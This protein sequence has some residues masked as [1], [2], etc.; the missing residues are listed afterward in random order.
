MTNDLAISILQQLASATVLGSLF[1][2]G[3]AIAFRWIRNTSATLRHLACLLAILVPAAFPVITSIAPAWRILP[4]EFASVWSSRPIFVHG[5]FASP[6]DPTDLSDRTDQTN[7]VKPAQP[8]AHAPVQ[9]GGSTAALGVSVWLFGVATCVATYLCGLFSLWRLQRRSTIC[10]DA[11]LRRTLRTAKAKTQVRRNVH[12]LLSDHRSMP[13][14]WGILRPQIL[15]PSD[16]VQWSPAAVESVMMHELAHV[17][18]QDALTGTVALLSRSV[19]WFSP[20]SWWITRRLRR[21]CEQACDDLLLRLGTDACDYAQTLLAITRSSHA[22]QRHPAAA[23][24]MSEPKSELARRVAAILDDAPDHHRGLSKSSATSLVTAFGCVL[25]VT[26]VVRCEQ[27]EVNLSPPSVSASA[28]SNQ[29]S[30]EIVRIG[31]VDDSAEGV[32]SI[33]GSGHAVFFSRP[34]NVKQIAAVEIFASRYG[35]VD[36]PN[37]DFHLYLL[38]EH[39]ELIAAYP[40]PYSTITRGDHRWYTFP[41]HGRK[42]PEKFYVALAF[43]PHRTKGIYLGYDESVKESHSF[44]GRPTTGFQTIGFQAVDQPRDWMIRVVLTNENRPSNPFE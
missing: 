2:I 23:L 14:Q 44:V 7:Q 36:P 16:V 41:I 22:N 21:E 33:A 1:A 6:Q 9:T 25:C 29:G 17:R 18:R 32:R 34:K 3:V 13:M 15:L 10:C 12:L 42:V 8:V 35:T 39:Q 4:R 37:E 30:A 31:Y 40:I 38:D 27:P 24:C 26:A 43:N 19:F 11:R 20:F 5:V 28:E